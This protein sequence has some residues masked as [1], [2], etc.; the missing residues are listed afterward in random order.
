MSV[1]KCETEAANIVLV[2]SFNPSIF[3]PAWLAAQGLIRPEEAKEAKVDIIAQA[4]SSFTAG[5]LVLQVTADRFSATTSS[6]AESPALRDL[7]VGI[8]RLL[9]HTPFHS[10][11]INRHMHY[12]MPSEEVWHGFGD[13][14]VPKGSWKELLDDPRTLSLVVRGKSRS[15]PGA[16]LNVKVES[17]ARIQNGIY[18]ETN[19]HY[20]VE[21]TG[22]PQKLLDILRERWDGAQAEAK[23]VAESLLSRAV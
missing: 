15:W 20:Q 3:Q 21:D 10:M 14:L 12:Q 17:S 7:A 8:F 6:M 5:W 1:P 2:G 18:V 13:R 19:E 9:E 16:T 4:V 23:A 22:A 11:G